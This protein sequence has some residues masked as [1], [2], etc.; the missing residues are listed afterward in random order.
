MRDMAFDVF[1]RS[2]QRGLFVFPLGLLYMCHDLYENRPETA[3]AQ[4]GPS[5]AGN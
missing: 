4:L 5:A 1:C 3:A 2:R